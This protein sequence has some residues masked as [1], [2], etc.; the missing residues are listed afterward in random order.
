MRIDAKRLLADLREL[1]QFG[2]YKTGVNR[3][4]FSSPDIEARRWLCSKM[5]EA[6]LAAEIDRFGNVYG[7]TPGVQRA[8][9]VGSHTDSVP[10]GGW[11]DGSL[12]TIYGLEIARCFVERGKGDI[13]VD[14]VSFQDEEGTFL[15]LLG[16]RSFC[17]DDVR[18]EVA[19]AKDKDGNSLAAAI[20]GVRLPD[21]D[22]ARLNPARHLGFFEAHIE[23][24]PRLEGSKFQIGV[25]TAIVGIRTLRVQFVGQ[26]D[27]AGTTPMAMRRD[28]GAAALKFGTLLTESL[29]SSA[30][31][32]TVWNFGGITFRPG[33]ANVVP[34][35]AELFFQ[36]RDT[37]PATLE[38][39]ERRAREL[40]DECARFFQVACDIAVVLNVPPTTMDAQ[41]A[42]FVDR[43]ATELGAAHI[44][45]PS[46]AGHDAMVLARCIPAAMLFVPSINGRSHDITEDTSEDHIV[47]GA[48]VLLRAVEL[49]AESRRVPLAAV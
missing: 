38:T 47:T 23:Q 8:V 31:A 4:A 1:S 28:A 17:G 49:F 22:P 13:G 24:G 37:D 39:V 19:R 16:S 25:V 43:A 11:L 40:A 20:A 27:H 32:D 5:A 48:Q 18:A 30:G 29:K 41:L 26:A 9:L 21:R 36:A 42:S 15:S 7:R 34:S 6:G 10:F 46:G 44:A 33:A 45:M 12:G 3:P 35:E 2:K 14:T